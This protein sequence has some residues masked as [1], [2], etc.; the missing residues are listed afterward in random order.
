MRPG[1]EALHLRSRPLLEL[2]CLG[3]LH[4]AFVRRFRAADCV[5]LLCARYTACGVRLPNARCGR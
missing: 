5:A 1:A 4:A 3:G 2:F